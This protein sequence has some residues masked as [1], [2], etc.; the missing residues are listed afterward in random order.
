MG[1]T[2]PNGLYLGDLALFGLCVTTPPIVEGMVFGLVK[3]YGVDE[4]V[5]DGA[6]CGNPSGLVLELDAVAAVLDGCFEVT[7]ATLLL[8]VA[9]W[10]AFGDGKYA[11]AEVGALGDGISI[12]RESF[13]GDPS[14]FPGDRGFLLGDPIASVEPFPTPVGAN[15]LRSTLANGFALCTALES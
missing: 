8:I 15:V 13:I 7:A 1:E 11:G 2:D 12:L 10:G 5:V 4:D 3:L 9:S 14:E 6:G